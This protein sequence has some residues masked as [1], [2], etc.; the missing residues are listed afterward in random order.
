M[1]YLSDLQKEQFW[2]EGVLV[3][4]DAVSDV[5]TSMLVPYSVRMG[6]RK[7]ETICRITA[8]HLM[9]EHGLNHPSARHSAVLPG[10]RRAVA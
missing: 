4:E 6:R 8:K 2:R 9:V 1:A 10:L 7:S 3:V 5:P